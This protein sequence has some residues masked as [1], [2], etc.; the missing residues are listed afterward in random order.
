MPPFRPPTLLTSPALPAAE[1]DA[2]R[3]YAEQEK[4]AATRRA[5]RSDWRLFLAWCGARNTCPLPAST[6]T[7]AAFLADEATAGAKASTIGRR[8][9]GSLQSDSASSRR[10]RAPNQPGGGAGGTAR[11]PPHHRR[12]GGAQGPSHC[13]HTHRDAAAL[14]TDA[15][16]QAGSRVARSG[17]RRC[18][19]TLRAGRPRGRRSDRDARRA[20]RADP[21]QQDRPGRA[22]GGDR[23]ST[24]LP[25]APLE[26]V[27][28]W[29]AA[30]EIN[31]GPLFRPVLKG[32][33]ISLS[34][35]SPFSVAL[36]VKRYAERAGLDA[37]AYAGH[38]LRSGLL[39]SAAEAGASV[40][41]MVEVS[42]HKSLDTLRGYVCRVD[43]FKE[44][45][46]A[47]S[48]DQKARGKCSDR[49]RARARRMAAPGRNC[50]AEFWRD[51]VAY[52]EMLGASSV[53]QDS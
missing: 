52:R 16:R 25:P 21:A 42:R 1:L 47:A 17:L 41:K 31:A 50:A 49:I 27:Q 6:D 3:L 34:P 8:V 36:I 5:Y 19:P 14:P 13:Q 43:M 4:A 45:A 51:R 40:L 39:T 9:A 7:V 11:H 24:R 37:A 26:A 53:R 32:G 10:P 48:Y 35:L 23:H 38:S 30:A 20:A 46:G 15:R 28:A 33:R 44:H 22:G 29:L 12:S 2:A 18:V